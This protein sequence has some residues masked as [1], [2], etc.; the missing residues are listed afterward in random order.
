MAGGNEFVA[1]FLQLLLLN[2]LLDHLVAADRAAFDERCRREPGEIVKLALR[3]YGNLTVSQLQA[4]VEPLLPAGEDWKKFW[5]L[6]RRQL[7]RVS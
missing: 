2:G 4:K 6:A 1:L 5:D 7:E 3:T